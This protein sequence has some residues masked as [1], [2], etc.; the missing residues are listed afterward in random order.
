MQV[1]LMNMTSENKSLNKSWTVI[2]TVEAKLKEP[3]TVEDPVILISR[4]R[5]NLINCNY[6]YIAEMGRY[7]FVKDN[8][9]LANGMYQITLHVDVLQTYRAFVKSLTTLITRQENLVSDY[10]VDNELVPRTK[11]DTIIKNVGTFGDDYG[12]YLTVAGPK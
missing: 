9:L 4:E 5:G 1:T 7:Y 3:C 6:I 10:I 12:F 8:L 11:R 2:S